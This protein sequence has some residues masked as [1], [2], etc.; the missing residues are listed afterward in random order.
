MRDP[1]SHRLPVRRGLRAGSQA[2][3]SDPDAAKARRWARGWRMPV[4]RYVLPA[5]VI[6]VGLIFMALGGETDV[7][8]GAAL[9]SAGTGTYLVNWLFRIGAAGDSER[10][11]E[12]AAREH[13]ERHGRWPA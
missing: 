11:A 12:D 6:V 7:E 3:A 8:G 1:A 4:I 10:E 5:V 13:F 2:M 9:V